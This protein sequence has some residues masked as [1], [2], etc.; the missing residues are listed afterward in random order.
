MFGVDFVNQVNVGIH[1]ITKVTDG[2]LM[3]LCFVRKEEED[4]VSVCDF[5]L[6]DLTFGDAMSIR[7]VVRREITERF[8][9]VSVIVVNEKGDFGICFTV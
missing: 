7:G 5:F 9:K 3:E 1:F 4:T 8:S 2:F 6:E